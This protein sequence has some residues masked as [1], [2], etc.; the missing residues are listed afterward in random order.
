MKYP[1][2]ELSTD[3]RNDRDLIAEQAGKFQELLGDLEDLL[4]SGFFLS[5]MGRVVVDEKRVFEILN[6]L[7]SLDFNIEPE[8]KAPAGGP[9]PSAVQPPEDADEHIRRAYAEAQNIRRGAD[10]YA[11]K[12]LEDIGGMLE[13]M[14]GSVN[15]GVRVLDDRLE[16]YRKLAG[17]EA[18]RVA[19]N[20][21]T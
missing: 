11:H 8:M 20:G 6:E 7:R 1:E 16:K 15:E 21:G 4:D 5:M 12:V 13:K 17:E 3:R 18:N 9:E 14:L 19:D 10:E 2:D